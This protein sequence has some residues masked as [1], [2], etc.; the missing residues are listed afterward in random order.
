MSDIHKDLRRKENKLTQSEIQ[1]R[2]NK[3]HQVKSVGTV[4]ALVNDD[5]RAL[6]ERWSALPKKKEAFIKAMN[7]YFDTLD[8]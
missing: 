1:A 7:D 6:Y 3:K 5:E 8:K 2:Y 4:L